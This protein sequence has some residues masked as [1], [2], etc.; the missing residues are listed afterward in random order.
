MKIPKTYLFC[1]KDETVSPQYQESFIKVGG[2]DEVIRVSAGHVPFVSQPAKVA[3]V[4]RDVAT[5][6]T[7]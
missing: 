5:A 3:E 1:E 7:I 2:F 6:S 4:I